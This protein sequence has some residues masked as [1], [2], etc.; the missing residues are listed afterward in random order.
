MAKNKNKKKKEALKVL[1]TDTYY[2]L[3]KTRHEHEIE[4]VI[5]V[6]DTEK[7]TLVEMFVADNGSWSA[8][9][10]GKKVASVMDTGDSYEWKVSPLETEPDYS[11]AYIMMV[12]LNFLDTLQ[13]NRP[14]YEIV[15]AGKVLNVTHQ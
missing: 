8:D 10:A 3:D 2:V 12:L 5:N 4:Y 1:H 6:H 15:I 11:G 9:H 14:S 7:G 13:T